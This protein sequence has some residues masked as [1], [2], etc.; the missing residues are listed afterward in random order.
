MPDI[1][2][3]TVPSD[4]NPADMRLRDPTVPSSPSSYY[5]ILKRR[6]SGAWQK[7]KLMLET[8]GTGHAATMYVRV[9]GVQRSVD[10]TGV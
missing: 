7:A 3:Y 10:T 2:H 5:A 4:T 1:Y 6:I 9:G 8:G